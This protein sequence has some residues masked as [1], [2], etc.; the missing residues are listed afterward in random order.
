M[1]MVPIP[2]K[3]IVALLA[4]LIILL[5]V[6]KKKK[7]ISLFIILTAG[8]GIGY[9][10]N[11]YNE[12]S[13]DYS[14]VN[15]DIKISA[16]SFIHEYETNDSA[17]NLKYLDR[18]VETEGTIKKIEKDEKGYYTVVLGDTA[19]L[20]SVRCSMDTLHN[21]DAAHL[22]AGSSATVRGKCTGFNK[23]EMGL[24][25]DVILNRCAIITKKD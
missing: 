19:N 16:V 2:M 5:F 4:F 3:I 7:I 15:P 17:A 24:G 22:K 20:S 10:V 23:D 14:H 1:T 11:L 13:P 21:E 6:V 18:V 25:S 12:K 8:A 9:A